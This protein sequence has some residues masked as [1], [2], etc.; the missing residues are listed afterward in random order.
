MLKMVINKGILKLHC[1]GFQNNFEH[2]FVQL[3]YP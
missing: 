3:L 1:S 2:I